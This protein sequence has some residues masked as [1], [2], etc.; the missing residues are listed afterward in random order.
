[1]K[2]WTSALIDALA[3]SAFAAIG[4]LSHHEL[5]DVSGTWRTAWPF[6]AGAAIGTIA[7][8]SWRRPGSLA[9]GVVIWACTVIIGMVLRVLSGNTIAVS[10]VIVTAVTLGVLLLGWRA[11]CGLVGRTR[12][13]QRVGA[14]A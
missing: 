9:G 11:I 1:M 6:L 3:V 4:R 2:F 12:N 7:A 14:D 8:R 5:T 13:R 10:F